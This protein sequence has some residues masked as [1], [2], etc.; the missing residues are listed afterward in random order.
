MIPTNRALLL[1]ETFRRI[2]WAASFQTGAR[3]GARTHDRE[4]T[5]LVRSGVC[6]IRT[7]NGVLPIVVKLTIEIDYYQQC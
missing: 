3:R 1:N 5:S 7:S 6:T 4:I 2:E